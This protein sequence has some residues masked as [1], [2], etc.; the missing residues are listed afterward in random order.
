[1]F[2]SKERTQHFLGAF[3]LSLPITVPLL[4]ALGVW[5]W[6][7][8][9]IFLWAAGSLIVLFFGVVVWFRR[10]QAKQLKRE[11]VAF[12]ALNDEE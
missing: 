5:I 6:S 11:S 1:M 8:P 10:S 2:D 12:D 3:I 7:L 4:F 9:Q